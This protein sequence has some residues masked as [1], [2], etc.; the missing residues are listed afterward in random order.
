MK[1]QTIH[2]AK[3]WLQ[4]FM[5]SVMGTDKPENFHYDHQNF[6]TINQDVHMNYIHI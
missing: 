3:N 2:Y 6:D 5:H 4:H 1:Y